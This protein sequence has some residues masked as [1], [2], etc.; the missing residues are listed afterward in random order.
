MSS[1]LNH[2][3]LRVLKKGFLTALND[4]SSGLQ[5]KCFT[6]REVY[7]KTGLFG[8]LPPVIP[9]VIQELENEGLVEECEDRNQIRITAQ[10]RR[11]LERTIDNNIKYI[12]E[13]INEQPTDENGQVILNGQQIKDLTGLT[14]SEINDAIAILVEN[15][16]VE[17]FNA[18]GTHPYTFYSIKL[19]PKGKFA[20]QL[21]NKEKNQPENSKKVDTK[22]T[23][24]RPIDPVGS[25]YGFTEDDWEEVY[26][27]QHNNSII[28]VVFGFQFESN[29]YNTET[30]KINIKTMFEESVQEYKKTIN[31]LDI[32]L[33]FKYL[34]AGYGG[35]LFNR[36]A[37][38]IISSDIAVFDISDKNPNVMIELGVA[39]TWGIRVLQILSDS[40]STRQ[41]SD[42]SG[43]TW[44]QYSNDGKKFLDPDH[45][46][47]LVNMIRR[48]AQSK[49]RRT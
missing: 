31:A 7:D 23:F 4:L 34:A 44:T 29:F 36:I 13:I 19:T 20:Y 49:Q 14:P 25:P 26:I 37:S 17:T 28:Y 3:D 40:S 35:H 48:A 47:K 1:A 10:G 18:L 39:L 43:H 8:Y 11:S 6:K 24:Y 33:D 32:T 22:E 41:P 45:Q 21:R 5:D 27:K 42:I 12:L 46:E 38:D 16:F 30:L 2:R 9:Y 15:G